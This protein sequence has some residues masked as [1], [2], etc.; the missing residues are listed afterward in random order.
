MG[1]VEMVQRILEVLPMAIHREDADKKNVLLLAVE[2]KHPDIYKLLLK[3]FPPEHSIYK[4]VDKN[5][6]NAFHLA[7]TTGA[8]PHWRITG[9]AFQMQWE[10]KWYKVTQISLSLSEPWLGLYLWAILCYLGNVTHIQ[11][12]QC[13][14]EL[15]LSCPLNKGSYKGFSFYHAIL[16]F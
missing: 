8:D 1:V 10:L 16:A 13:V 14:N 6:N 5:G 9:I 11:G 2:N 4:K 7:A 12:L 3:K 15:K